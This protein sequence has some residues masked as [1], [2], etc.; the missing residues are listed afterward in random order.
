MQYIAEAVLNGHPDKFSDLLADR[1]IRTLYARDPEAYA[2]IEVA[3]WS[4]QVFLTGA[5]VTHQEVRMDIRGELIRLGEEIGYG[6]DNHIDV[7]QYQIH[8]H[9]C[10]LVGKPS[11]WTHFS[12]DQNVVIAYA[13]YNQLTNYLPPEQFAVYFFREKILEALKQDALIGHGPDGKLLIEVREE[14]GSFYL[15]KFLISLQQHADANF[16]AFSSALEAALHQTYIDLQRHDARWIKDWGEVALLLNPNGPWLNGGSDGD[17][18]QTGRKLVMDYYGPRVPL[19]GGALYGKDLS[20]IDRLG[21]FV[22][23]QLAVKQ[24]KRGAQSCMIKLAF[25]PGMEKPISFD[26][27]TDIPLDIDWQDHFSFSNMR[28]T[29]D[30]RAMDYSLEKLG[31]FYNEELNF[32]Q[33]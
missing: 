16:I 14:G 29:I 19:G 12:N 1:I 31:T 6:P 13:G 28:Q 33:P 17:N 30:V 26:V 27:D 23:R 32:N 2:Q 4:D 22:A 24:V 11:T 18:G 3:V 15:N 8:D 9:I 25:A 21:S 20:H 5:W 7:H 10:K